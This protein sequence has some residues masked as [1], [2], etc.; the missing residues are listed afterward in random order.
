[1]GWYSAAVFV[2]LIHQNIIINIIKQL[3]L[4][5]FGNLRGLNIGVGRWFV[6]GQ[7]CLGFS[8][9][10]ACVVFS[11]FSF[12]ELCMEMAVHSPGTNYPK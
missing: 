2:L 4:I 9:I 7:F 5:L 10:R 1:M 11:L 3:L 12:L 8:N 6:C